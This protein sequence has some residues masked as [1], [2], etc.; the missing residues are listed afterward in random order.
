MSARISF[1]F[2]TSHN[3]KIQVQEER[4]TISAA[5]KYAHIDYREIITKQQQKERI[6]ITFERNFRYLYYNYHQARL[7]AH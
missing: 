4:L 2:V 6:Q 1:A 7:A 3:A 5:A